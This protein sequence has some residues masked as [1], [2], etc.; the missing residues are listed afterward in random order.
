M[1][2]TTTPS[3]AAL[4]Y[5]G[6]FVPLP[7]VPDAPGFQGFQCEVLDVP[8]AAQ[9]CLRCS[10][11][12]APGCPMSP[13]ILQRVINT[14]RPDDFAMSIALDGGAQ[15]GVSVTE[16]LGCPRKLRLE[17]QNGYYVKPS[18]MT[19]ILVGDSVHGALANY[20]ADN[21]L[22]EVRLQWRFAY[23]NESLG[24]PR[25]SVILTGQ[26][27]L[28]ELTP[29]GWFIT[30]YKF[31]Q[32]APRR[33]YSFACVNCGEEVLTGITDRRRLAKI[34]LVCRNCGGL[35]RKD[36]VEIPM[37]PQ[38]R[39]GHAMQVA[40]YALLVQKNAALFAQLLKDRNPDAPAD[41]NTPIAGA[42]IIYLPGPIRCPVEVDINAAFALVK[43]RL[44][45]LLQ[46]KLPG[47]VTEKD[48]LWQCNYCPVR[49]AC[50]REHGGPVGSEAELADE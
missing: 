27:D 5:G 4:P 24:I 12:G 41:E 46:P 38:A 15:F 45:A 33:S 30:D 1:V 50:E 40:L 18:S 47:I 16:L 44:T 11:H 20:E 31:T 6:S 34:P 48:N 25:T 17:A 32:N 23:G 28:A 2:A 29:A 37:P 36:V 3:T 14:Q 43:Q 49:Y 22:P 39:S 13:A 35:T 8:V 21:A 7:A 10:Q 26:I 19:S 42:Q 9:D